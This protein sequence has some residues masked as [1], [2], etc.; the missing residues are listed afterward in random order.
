MIEEKKSY[1]CPHGELV[2]E[3]CLLYCPLHGLLGQR[4]TEPEH[5]DEP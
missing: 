2:G 4:A 1:L 5:P 3:T